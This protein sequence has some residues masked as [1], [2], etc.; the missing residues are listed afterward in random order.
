MVEVLLP[1]S[2]VGSMQLPAGEDPE[3]LSKDQKECPDIGPS[4]PTQSEGDHYSNL[5]AAGEGQHKCQL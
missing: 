2:S 3:I 4:V 5:F 1:D